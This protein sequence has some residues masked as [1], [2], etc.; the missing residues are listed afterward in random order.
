MN[1]SETAP[2]DKMSDEELKRL[3][4]D[5]L[6]AGRVV[7]GI[8]TGVFFVGLLLYSFIFWIASSR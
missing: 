2:N 7:A 1:T 4:A 3:H 5:D 6:Q 8:M